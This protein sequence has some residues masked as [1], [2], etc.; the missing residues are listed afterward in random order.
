ML[1]RR[2][3]VMLVL[4][5]NPGVTVL[6]LAALSHEHVCNVRTYL[7][8]ATHSGA[9]KVEQP[10]GLRRYT[11][12]DGWLAKLEVHE[13]NPRVRA[14]DKTPKRNPERLQDVRVKELR[15][16]DPAV[17]PGVKTS[18]VKPPRKVNPHHWH[19]ASQGMGVA[20]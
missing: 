10:R 8:L 7:M 2:H 14:G 5:R 12:C 3:K 9:V 20:A 18:W 15:K 16:L 19:Q 11:I 1:T 13:S 6:E 17:K 4:E